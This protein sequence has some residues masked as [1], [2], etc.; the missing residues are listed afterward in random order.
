MEVDGNSFGHYTAEIKS[1]E[2]HWYK[3]NDEKM[4]KRIKDSE[5]TKQ[6]YIFLFKNVDA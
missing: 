4:P 2:N 5:L 3:T 6:G 1:K